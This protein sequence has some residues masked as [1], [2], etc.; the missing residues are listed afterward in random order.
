MKDSFRTLKDTAEGLYKEKGSKFIARAYAVEDEETV[1]EKLEEVR[2]AHHGARH[3]CYAYIIGAEQKEYRVNDDGEPSGTAG[4]PIYN[5]IVSRGLTDVLVVVT[6][7]FGGTKLGASGLVNAYKTAARE[8]LGNANIIQKSI[9][10]IYTLVYDY[11][12]TNE[13]M[14]ILND[15]QVRIIEQEFQAE[16]KA[17]IGMRKNLAPEFEASV[18]KNKKLKIKHVKSEKYP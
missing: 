11:P 2:K 17:M 13:V 5:Q 12:E 6:R 4:R 15:F 10:E 3:H 18:G 1:R 9:Q 14:R 7:Y 16:C 8:A